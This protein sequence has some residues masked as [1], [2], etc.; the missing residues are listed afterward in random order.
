MKKVLF[1]ALFGILF[2]VGCSNQKKSTEAASEEA[3]EQLY[4][5]SDDV[6]EEAVEAIDDSGEMSQDSTEEVE[7][8]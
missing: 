2:L 7:S 6:N 1:I 8:E 3:S 4:E 5:A